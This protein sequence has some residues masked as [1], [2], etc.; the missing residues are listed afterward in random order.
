MPSDARDRLRR[1]S[2]RFSKSWLAPTLA[3]GLLLSCWCA[4][5]CGSKSSDAAVNVSTP[6]CVEPGAEVGPA[7]LRRLTRFEYGRTVQGL[8]GVDPAIADNLPPDEVSQGFDNLAEAYSVSSLHATKYLEVAEKIASA[9][10]ADRERLNAF[11]GCDPTAEPSCVEPFVRAF[12]RQAY[13]R[14]LLAEEL[15]SLLTLQQKTADPDAAAGVSAV[16]ATVLQAPQFLYRPEAPR[17]PDAGAVPLDDYGL[18]TRLSYLIVAAAPDEQL[19]AAAEGGALQSDV[20]LV[21]EAERLL[22]APQ[23]A[24]AFGHFVS[25]WWGLE[26]LSELEKDRALFRQWSSELPAAFAEETRL[27]LADAWRRGPTLRALLGSPA[28]F[29]D[30]NLA[31][32]YGYPLPRASGFQRIELDPT[33]AFGLLTQ[34]A[35]LA[36]HAKPNQTSPVHRGQF[37]RARLFCSPPPPPPSDIVVRPPTVDPRLSTRER[38]L[39]HEADPLCAGCHQLMDPIGLAFEHFDATGR[40]RDVDAGKPI[41]A[42]G[43]LTG[44]DVDGA[45]DGVASLSARLIES[46]EVR[47]CVATQWFRYAFG[48]TEQTS[49]DRCTIDAL[50]QILE[51]GEGDL[52]HLIRATVQQ[53]IFRLA[54]RSEGAP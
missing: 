14:P 38:F 4:A 36:T 8:T 15:A 2:E 24:S 30:A 42:S 22:Q 53:S 16:V 17:T 35:F 32:F 46:Q 19:L 26:S 48:R 18:A 51:K 25:Q 10:L 43:A 44:T 40:Y 33:R 37:V 5:G 12:G 20:G 27:F 52:R 34:G 6:I 7:P 39:Q 9:L 28:T 47:R 23:A 54:Q 21:A 31:S 1:G 41:D 11:A 50:G 49:A 45:L 13:R 29:V 3:G